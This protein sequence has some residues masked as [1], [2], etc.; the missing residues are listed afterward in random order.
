MLDF[1]PTY[2]FNRKLG[3][4]ALKMYG[5]GFGSLEEKIT[6]E[7][8]FLVRRL[9]ETCA[10]PFDV[11]FMI[12]N[13]VL[14]VI[15]SM[16][17]GNRYDIKDPDFQTVIKYTHLLTGTPRRTDISF[18]FPW[19]RSFYESPNFKRI[20]EGK[21]LRDEYI[22]KRTEEHEKSLNPDQVRDFCDFLLNSVQE[23]RESWNE[24]VDTEEEIHNQIHMI[25][26]NMIAAGSETSASVLSWAVVYLLHWPHLQ[27][28]LLD[29]IIEVVGPNDFAGWKDRSR[30]H[31]C[32]AFLQET[33]RMATIVPLVDHKSTKASS[34]SG[35]S[36]SKGTSVLFNIWACHH[37]TKEWKDPEM[38]NPRRWLDEEGKC[39]AGHTQSYLPFG[40]GRRNCLGEVLAKE[41]MFLFFTRLVRC[42]S[43]EPDNSSPLP[44][45]GDGDLGITFAPRPF[46]AK[47]VPRNI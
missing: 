45:L 13:S 16:L 27:Q 46:T 7:A 39:M 22:R 18:L 31:L 34:I 32:Q 2:R 9:Q 19:T 11:R 21:S 26:A 3:H 37:D 25:L 42:F 40:A 36:L 28:E 10:K 47:F 17:F 8:D 44:V 30:L 5:E 4:K 20:M 14:N 35:H 15:C 43:I 6:M 29:E 1:S 33:L 24:V 41:E 38:F 12:S 23:D